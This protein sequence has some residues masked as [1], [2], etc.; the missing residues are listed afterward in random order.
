MAG[1]SDGAAVGIDVGTTYS[2]V[3]VYRSNWVEI[4]ENDVGKKK[5]P[6]CIA[7]TDTKRLIGEAAMNHL[8]MHPSNAI[9]DTKR[10]IGRR[11]TD[12]YLQSDMNKWPFKVMKDPDANRPMIVILRKGEMKQFAPQEILSM[13][14]TKMCETAEAHIGYP[15]KNA[16]I[17]VPASFSVSQRQAMKDAATITGL[18]VLQIISEP[19]A[20]AIAYAFINNVGNGKRKNVLV[21]DL[22]G[23]SLDVSLIAIENGTFEV[24]STAGDAHLGGE[25]FSNR[26]VD[27]LVQEFKIKHGKDI[28][29]DH[30]ALGR[31]RASCE[32]AKHELSSS[33]IPATIDIDCL[34]D[35]ID[36]TSTITRNK[37]VSLNFDL[38]HRC[39]QIVEDCWS[40]ANIVKDSIYEILL[41]GGSTRVPLVQE[42]LRQLFPV[43]QLCKRVNADEAVAIEANTMEVPDLN[44]DDVTPRSL[45]L[46][47]NYGHHLK[48]ISKN[49][50]VP[51]RRILSVPFKTFCDYRPTIL[52]HVFEENEGW[53]MDYN[54]V[55]EFTVPCTSLAS[56]DPF[57]MKICFEINK[58]GILNIS[59]DDKMTF[60]AGQ[61]R[62]EEMK[63]MVDNA[64]KLKLSRT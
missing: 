30:K 10:L 7:F 26:I 53:P 37:F 59:V 40:K 48:I 3:G 39:I 4:I 32:K 5:T 18:N 51:N 58:D 17:S 12:A 23:G 1:R 33:L 60:T 8:I 44:I 13:L 61:L 2:C 29:S 6:S 50:A 19:T 20:A 55:H 52:F 49:T 46:S 28:S 25:D 45:F 64:N 16:V 54:L 31:L 11:F 22:G 34:C 57:T 62:E 41:I 43:K 27:Y 42:L 63:K 56:G 21:F 15:V 14:L 35:D 9:F 38:F 36:F 24:I 47:S